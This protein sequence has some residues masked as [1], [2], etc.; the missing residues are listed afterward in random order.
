MTISRDPGIWLAAILTL[1]VYSFLFKENLVSRWIEHLFIG[2]GAGYAL[3]LGFNN[4]KTKALVPIANGSNLAML[5]PL[6]IGLLLFTRFFHRVSYLARIPLALMTGVG[7]GLTLRGTVVADFIGQIRAAIAPINS[8]NSLLMVAG[9]LG[10]LLYFLFTTKPNRLVSYGASFGQ[11]VMMIAF[12]A[13][14]GNATMGRI[15]QLIG[16]LD[17]LLSKWLGLYAR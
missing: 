3:V 12:G 6:I 13:G 5:V 2:L 17:L 9:T 11:V 14:F 16:R 7:T 1:G 4:L 15:S 10:T 8:V